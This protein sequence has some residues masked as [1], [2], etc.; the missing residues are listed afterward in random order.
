MNA[1]QIEKIEVLKK[2]PVK[3]DAAGTG[4]MINIKT[5]KLKLVGF[6]GSVFAS[7][8]QGFYGNP[9]GGFTLNYKGRKVN[10]FSG[11]TAAQEWR[12]MYE[13]F[14]NEFNY[15]GTTTN[16][17]QARY[18]TKEHHHL[19]TYNLGADWFI[20]KYNSVGIKMNGAF[21]M[22]NVD[23]IS[24]T[25]FSDTLLGY[26]KLILNSNKP[27]PWIYPE[28]NINAEH[29]FDSAG[30]ALRFSANYNPY[31][32]IYAANFS[33]Q[34]LDA[35]NNYVSTPSVFKTSNTLTGV[36]RPLPLRERRGV[37]RHPL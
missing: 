2:P 9:S 18:I 16:I 21:G 12:R 7:H 4:G 10:L 36:H 29:L 26:Q 23:N 20:N 11:F 35:E 28:F 6:S 27:N 5:N 25:N 19:E 30:T 17:T 15:N 37:G 3:Y 34:F 1:S 32:D 14:D 13:E 8:S 22:G 24:T 31:W 33:N